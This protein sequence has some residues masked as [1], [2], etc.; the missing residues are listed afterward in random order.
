MPRRN[1]KS[2]GRA[3]VALALLVY[4]A[5]G[6]ASA[7][8]PDSRMPWLVAIAGTA[9]VIAAAVSILAQLRDNFQ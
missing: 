5:A 9:L 3:I 1:G 6:I 8:L 4:A 2:T 7:Y